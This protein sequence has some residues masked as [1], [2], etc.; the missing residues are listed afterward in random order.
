MPFPARRGGDQTK[1]KRRERKT[2][3]MNKCCDSETQCETSCET[4]ECKPSCHTEVECPIQCAADKWKDS[5]CQAMAEVQV[6]ILK[7]KILKAHGPMLEQAADACLEAAMACWHLQ[8]SKIKQ[9]QAGEA[10]K[11]KL[12]ELWTHEQK[13]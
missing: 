4:E 13:P 5:F 10:L 9:Q 12:L 3:K 6:D 1:P 8:I 11:A 2:N 7:A